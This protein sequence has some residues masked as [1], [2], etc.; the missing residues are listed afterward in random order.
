MKT[1]GITTLLKE[2]DALEDKMKSLLNDEELKNKT[3]LVKVPKKGYNDA[4]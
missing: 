4:Y 3:E 2:L 1:I